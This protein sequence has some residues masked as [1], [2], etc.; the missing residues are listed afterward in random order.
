MT[1]R[2]PGE[3]RDSDPGRADIAVLISYSGDGGVE[4]MINHL[5]QGFIEAGRRV[6][7]LALK[8]RGGHF[9]MLPGGAR[10]VSIRPGHS[11]L[12]VPAIARY[13][14]EARPRV[15]LAAKDRAGR[16]AIRARALAGSDARVVVR[17]GNNLSASL[18][19][20]APLQRWLRLRPIRRLYPLA[21]AIVAV[22]AGVADDVVATSGIDPE[23]V[24]IV[25]NPVVTPE[26]DRLAGAAP[27]HP[28][29][30]ADRPLIVAVGRL[31]RQKDF[32]TLLHAFAKLRE[33]RDARLLI[34]GEGEDRGVLE[35]L[36]A[37]LG[38]G[39][40]VDLAGFYANPYPVMAAADLFVLSSRWEGS[41]NALTEALYLGVPSV[42]TDCPSGPSDILPDERLAP[43]GDA[44]ALAAIMASTLCQPRGCGELR[45]AVADYTLARSAAK[46]LAVLDRI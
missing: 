34:M 16:A 22:S 8:Q 19:H 42:A 46:Y 30:G 43:V 5:V 20:R 6:D 14:R 9:R 32:P 25:A 28:W 27:E 10:V 26:V 31:T 7:V 2:G 33:A 45:A 35:A 13:L 17:I 29:V 39:D 44:G 1:V 15:L 41:P 37:R 23:R 21:D 38:L 18:A 40:C 12:A 24:H 3:E 36:V 11:A 4:R